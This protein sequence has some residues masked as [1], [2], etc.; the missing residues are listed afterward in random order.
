MRKV[1]L[2]PD[3][4]LRP[5]ALACSARRG[6]EHGHCPGYRRAIQRRGSIGDR[7]RVVP[8]HVCG[9]ASMHDEPVAV[10]AMACSS[11]GGSSGEVKDLFNKEG[12]RW[13]ATPVPG[14]GPDQ[15]PT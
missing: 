15:V 1:C 5:A 11:A 4:I 12:L 6:I 3:H 10:R 14:Q 7:V 8:D 13:L 2:S 9:T